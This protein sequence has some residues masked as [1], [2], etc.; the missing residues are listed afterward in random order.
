MRQENTEEMIPDHKLEIGERFHEEEVT[1][2]TELH[3]EA[4]DL[5]RKM[6]TI[7]IVAP[8]II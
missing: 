8:N 2:E 1:P 5:S 7:E 6:L 4:D 3:I